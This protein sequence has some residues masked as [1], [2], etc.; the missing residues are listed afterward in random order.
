MLLRKRSNNLFDDFFGD[1]F[2]DP[3]FEQ[4]TPQIMETDVLEKDGQY[5]LDIELPGYDKKDVQA[6]LKDGYLT[7]Q[8]N[9]DETIENKDEKS[10]F[11]RKERYSGSMKRT[12]YVGEDVTEEDIQAGFKDGILKVAIKKPETKQLK[13]EKKLI[14]IL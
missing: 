2:E 9:K 6:E 7:I 5:L 12:F 10:N 8:A 4:M 13:D 11:V 3:F 1:M 14:P